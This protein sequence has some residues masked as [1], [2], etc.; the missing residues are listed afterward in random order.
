MVAMHR[1]FVLS[2]SDLRYISINCKKC[3]A[4]VTLDMTRESDHQK[5]YG[6]A[7]MVC[8]ACKQGYD[9]AIRNLSGF[10]HA[11]QSLLCVAD[12]LTLRSGE[13]MADSTSSAFPASGDKD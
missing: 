3:S 10:R 7:P 8:P 4:S 12:Q 6:F 2:L 9:T 11:Y 5:Q 13:E 1:Q